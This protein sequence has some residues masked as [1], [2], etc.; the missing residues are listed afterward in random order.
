MKSWLWNLGAILRAVAAI[1][2]LLAFA[3]VCVRGGERR[4]ELADGLNG[5][6][7]TPEA[8]WDGRTMLLLHGFADDM[9]GAGNLYQKLA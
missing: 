2:L 1:P 3:D 8:S 6:W 5:A 4:I 7:R 9:D